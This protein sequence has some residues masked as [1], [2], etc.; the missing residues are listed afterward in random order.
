MVRNWDRSVKTAKA[1][2]RQS[3]GLTCQFHR[4]RHAPRRPA[5]NPSGS[6]L[7]PL[8]VQLHAPV[9][10]LPPS[11]KLHRAPLRI[12]GRAKHVQAA[13][14]HHG[15]TRAQIRLAGRWI[16]PAG[17][18]ACNLDGCNHADV[19]ADV[20]PHQRGG[21]PAVDEE[22]E[23]RGAVGVVVDGYGEEGR[24]GVGRTTRWED[25]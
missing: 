13:V 3:D 20:V 6:F 19:V 23:G 22:E 5:Q 25:G 2:L 10:L 7:Q 1:C 8:H 18:D 21:A 14:A 17:V 4:T 15:G 16:C 12:R 9:G 24:E 11:Q